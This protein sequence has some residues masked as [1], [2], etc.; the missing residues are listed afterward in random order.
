ML[1]KP[2]GIGG[3]LIV[4]FTVS[5][6]LY[7]EVASTGLKATPDLFGVFQEYGVSIEG[8]V[9]LS[10]YGALIT[11]LFVML[12]V[13]F[14]FFRKKASAVKWNIVLL[15]CVPAYLLAALGVA[16]FLGG[17]LTFPGI[18]FVFVLFIAWALVWTFYWLRSERVRNTFQSSS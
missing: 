14:L 15:W 4:Y 10:L 9:A 18:V 13:A 16:V 6:F 12:Y 2:S 7:A 11:P 8:L 3:W 5:L 1:K 17:T